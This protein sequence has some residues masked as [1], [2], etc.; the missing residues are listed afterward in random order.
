[1]FS[2]TACVYFFWA[3]LLHNKYKQ[4]LSDSI[5]NQHLPHSCFHLTHT[6]EHIHPGRAESPSHKHT[7]NSQESV[8]CR[9][10][11]RNNQGRS[12]VKYWSLRTVAV[13]GGGVLYTSWSVTCSEHRKHRKHFSPLTMCD[14]HH[15]RFLCLGV[16]VCQQHG[17]VCSWFYL[18]LQK[19][20]R[21]QDSW[22]I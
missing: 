7:Y 5:V 19:T 6:S 8:K 13:A 2:R 22:E 20:H 4:M 18:H 3:K 1:M 11:E 16:C 10:R 14:V 12:H 15:G 17:G 21:Q 9:V